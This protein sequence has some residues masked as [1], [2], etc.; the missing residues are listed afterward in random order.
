MSDIQEL[1]ALVHQLVA[2]VS[3]HEHLLISLHRNQL[4][5]DSA[6]SDASVDSDSE[7]IDVPANI[8]TL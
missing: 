6:N 2:S 3:L 1:T 4:L 7:N 5:I 8:S